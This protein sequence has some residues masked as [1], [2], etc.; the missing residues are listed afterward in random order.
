MSS[1]KSRGQRPVVSRMK[2]DELRELSD[3]ELEKKARDLKEELFNLRFQ[4]ITGQLENPIRL[5][6]VRRELARVKT[7]QRERELTAVKGGETGGGA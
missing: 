4:N 7:I 1:G 5:R 3:S 6:Q 2:A